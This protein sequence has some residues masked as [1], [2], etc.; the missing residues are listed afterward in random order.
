MLTKFFKKKQVTEFEFKKETTIEQRQQVAQNFK[1]KYPHCVPV[2]IKKNTR[3]KILQDIDKEKY[4]I[5][6]NLLFS[7]LH[8]MIR[9][10]INITPNQAIFVFVANGILVPINKLI[11]EIYNEYSHE[12]GFLYITYTA[13][14][15]FG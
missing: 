14:N 8:C 13:E 7:E 2:I 5:P 4:L 3:D 15:T 11:E 9:K 10:K 6:K 12:D 1:S